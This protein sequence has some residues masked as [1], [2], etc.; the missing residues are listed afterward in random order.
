[1]S[2]RLFLLLLI[3]SASVF[4]SLPA[5]AQS[6]SSAPVFTLNMTVTVTAQTPGSL[7]GDVSVNVLVTPINTTAI[8]VTLAS[9][10]RN[11][12]ALPATF[13]I[14]LG[15]VNG[16]SA[17]LNVLIENVNVTGGYLT[18]VINNANG[19]NAVMYQVTISGVTY[20]G[21]STYFYVPYQLPT[22][23]LPS[24]LSAV[25]AVMGFALLMAIGFRYNLRDT[26]IGLIVYGV[27]VGPVLASIGITS[28]FLTIVWA[29]S[30]FLGFVYILMSYKIER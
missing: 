3:I 24:L 18:V 22:V 13:N 12:T 19:Y 15:T 7:P 20:P 23:T 27:L 1:M 9:F 2:V 30:W 11:G 5:L 17:V 4:L 14:G 10:Y 16:S 21:G 6:S 28:P 8:N 25:A 29:L 26:G